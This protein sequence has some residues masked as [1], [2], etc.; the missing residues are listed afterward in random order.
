MEAAQQTCRGTSA[1]D[2]SVLS[3]EPDVEGHVF[4]AV[5]L[6]IEHDQQH[7]IDA[8]GIECLRSPENSDYLL[9]SCLLF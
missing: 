4:D 7:V 2:L 8:H 6:C 9:A 1:A 5:A 3:L